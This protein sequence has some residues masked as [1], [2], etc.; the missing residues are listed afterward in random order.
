MAP[1]S[2]DAPAIGVGRDL[3]LAYD[4]G[5]EHL[6]AAGPKCGVV[7][8]KTLGGKLLDADISAGDEI[9]WAAAEDGRKTV[10]T[11]LNSDQ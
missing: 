9:C 5:G 11:V 1:A 10:I 8:E 6:C 2:L 4:V 3:I 7:L